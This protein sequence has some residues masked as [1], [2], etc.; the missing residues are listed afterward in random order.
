MGTIIYSKLNDL[1]KRIKVEDEGKTLRKYI[2][3]SFQNISDRLISYE[4][5]YNTIISDSGNSNREIVDARVSGSGSTTYDTLKARLDAMQDMIDSS[6][7][8]ESI[9][10]LIFPIGFVVTLETNI[11]PNEIWGGKWIRTAKG[12]FIVGLNESE[13]EFKTLGG[14]GGEKTHV[15]TV[16]EIPSHSHGQIVT[17]G[18]GGSATRTDY[19]DDSKGQKYPQGVNTNATGGGKAHNNLPPYE[20]AYKWKRIA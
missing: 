7:T 12:K 9:V 6:Y 1:I 15:L 2:A 10:D 20:V 13:T 3:E 11:N 19:N 8:K 14:T 18:T 17:A 16:D 5:S 4:E